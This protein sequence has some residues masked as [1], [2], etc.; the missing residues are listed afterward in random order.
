MAAPKDTL[1]DYVRQ[2][3]ESTQRYAQDLLAEN[4]KL[5]ALAL[6]VHTEKTQLE[7]QVE[8][9][10][11]QLERHR[12]AERT[13]AE[14]MSDMESTRREL[15]SRYLDVEQSNTNLAHLYVASYGLHASLERDDVVRS[16]H[17]ILVNLVGSEDFAIV[18]RAS[19]GGPFTVTSSMGVSAER[20]ARIRPDEG[21]IGDSLTR[22]VT[23]VRSLDGQGRG[24]EEPTACIPLTVGG[25]VYGG[26]VVFGLLPHKPQLE[27]VDRELFDLLAT[28]AAS[29]LYCCELH[30][31][32]KLQVG[33]EA[34]Q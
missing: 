29:A 33:R 6:T 2:V 13:L 18:D 17:E 5:L 16:I 21:T 31:R 28:H 34:A 14:E 23:Y 1:G 24:P 10:R 26:I 22:G 7:E 32:V 15:S 4:E 9:L 3:R 11:T 12:A 19:E 30:A 20:C 25:R 8:T 27:A